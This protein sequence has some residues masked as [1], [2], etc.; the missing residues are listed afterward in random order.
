MV[1]S[2]PGRTEWRFSC[3][4]AGTSMNPPP[5]GIV[6]QDITHDGHNFAKDIRVIGFWVEMETVAP[7]GVVAPL[8]KQFFLLEAPN[9]AVSPITVLRPAP[10]TIPATG[11]T[12]AYLREV[13]SAL[14]FGAYFKDSAGNYVAFGVKAEF[15]AATFFSRFTSCE[16]LGLTVEQIFLFSAY[17]HDPRHEPSGALSAARCHPMLKYTTS[18]N[19]ALN[20][21][22]PY[23][24]IRNIRFD[25]RLHL[26]ID[27]HHNTATNAG[28]T[29]LGNQAGLF[30]D[31]DSLA[32]TTASAIGSTLWNLSRSTGVTR[33][34]FEAVEKPLVLEVTAPGLANGFPLYSSSPASQASSAVRCWDN[35]HWWGAR[36]PGAPL[37]STPGAF[38][39][40]HIHWRWGGAASPKVGGNPRFQGSWPSG[41]AA[42][43]VTGGKWGP[44]VDPNIWMQTIRIA[45]V[46]NDP[47]LDPARTPAT[48][49]SRA[50]W[51]TLFD[52]GLRAAP[53]DISAGDDIVLW[54]SVEVPREVTVPGF[55]T[56]TPPNYTTT[57]TTAYQARSPGTVFLSGIFFAH[58]AEVTGTFV[59]STAPAHRPRSESTIR[60]PPLQWFRPAN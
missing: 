18:P 60:T 31:S 55:S 41:Q 42:N 33:G 30:A 10:M 11:R 38:H 58:D 17:G 22:L 45:V 27:R 24:R 12:F 40:A 16:L 56:F 15:Q 35:V 8:P 37:I 47:R 9:F 49:L 21:M 14:D 23:T 39:A 54:Y 50:D 25:Y 46:K 48:N 53:A 51:K 43:P 26:Y 32:S 3:V 13:D 6:L 36:G 44:V 34:S 5:G 4:T 29:Q 28:L 1:L 52:P 2:D 7:G 59:G 57:P 20:R 19:P